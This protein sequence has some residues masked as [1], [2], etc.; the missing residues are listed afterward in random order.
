MLR[1]ALAL[2]LLLPATAL[3]APGDPPP[4]RSQTPFSPDA[5]RFEGYVRFGQLW[6]TDPAFD[7]VSGTDTL[8]R[9]ELGAGY[10][11]GG[12]LA[13]EAGY[14]F[15]SA[16]APLF[17]YGEASLDLH[18]IQAAAIYRL[19]TSART[20]A[21][22]RGQAS[23]DFAV[24]NVSGFGASDL[25]DLAILPGLEGTVGWEL[26][27]PLGRSRTADGRPLRHLA[28]G[29]EA[30]Y[31]FRP[32]EAEFGVAPDVDDDTKPRPIERIDTELGSLDLSSWVLR[33]GGAF[34]F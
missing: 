30:G 31:A 15:G 16:S 10:S 14:A 11:P 2:L 34:R 23:V 9:V 28:F 17:E 20:R 6:I 3:G 4:P 21:F 32:W 12:N 18:S 19:P 1:L 27:V 22:A 25:E 24:L 29:V 5:S 26:L 13:F 33:F 8:L 7:L